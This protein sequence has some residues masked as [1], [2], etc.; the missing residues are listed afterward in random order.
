[1]FET[2]LPSMLLFIKPS[3]RMHIIIHTHYT[4]LT[5]TPAHTVSHT[6]TCTHT[7]IYIHTQRSKSISNYQYIIK[8]IQAIIQLMSDC[9]CIMLVSNWSM[10]MHGQCMPNVKKPLHNLYNSTN[11]THRMLYTNKHSQP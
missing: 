11:I 9:Q 5:Q 8:A 6:H 2:Q 10:H 1:M 3:H 4:T 7:Y